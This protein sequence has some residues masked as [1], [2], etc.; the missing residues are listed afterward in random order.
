MN[1]KSTLQLSVN[2]IIVLILAT[3][4]L[5]IALGFIRSFFGGVSDNFLTLIEKEPE[6]PIPSSSKVITLSREKIKMQHGEPEVIKAAIYN[7]AQGEWSNIAPVVSC[8]VPLANEEIKINPK[9]IKQREYEIFNILFMIE[10]NLE[11]LYLC[12]IEIDDYYNEFILVFEEISGGGGGGP[13]GGASQEICQNAE[14]NNL[15]SGLDLAFGDGYRAECCS[16]FG[17]CC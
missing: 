12:R 16:N 4:V 11:N 3:V 7:P 6:P 8:S 15:C 9:T 14:N 5:V 17:L 1:K 13:G 2:G 10:S